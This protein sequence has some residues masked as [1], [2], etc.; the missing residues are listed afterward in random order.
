MRFN[1]LSII[2]ELLF[3]LFP[4]QDICLGYSLQDLNNILGYGFQEKTVYRLISKMKKVLTL[5]PNDKIQYDMLWVG[6][7]RH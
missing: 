7:I 1:I 6:H 3:N 2:V 4:N 5:Q